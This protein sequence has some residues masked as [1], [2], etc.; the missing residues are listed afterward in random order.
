MNFTRGCPYKSVFCPNHQGQLYRAGPVDEL[1]RFTS[2]AVADDLDLPEEAEL[3][4]AR[5]LQDHL[6]VKSAPQLRVALHLLTLVGCDSAELSDLLAALGNPVVATDRRAMSAWQIKEA[7]LMAKQALLTSGRL[8]R[9]PP[10]ILITSEDNTLVNKGVIR[11]YLGKRT[12]SGLDEY[13][14]FDP[15]QNTVWD[16]TDAYGNAD[17][18]YI[19]DLVRRNPFA[20]ALGVDG[21]SNPVIRQNSKPRYTIGNA[22]AVNR[23]LA[24]HGVVVTNNYILLTPETDLLEAVEA[25]ALFVLLPLPWRDYGHSV[26]LRVIKEEGT[27]AH[28]EGLIFAPDDAGWD[29]PLRF[30]EVADLLDRWSLTSRVASDELRPLLLKILAEDAA[31]A[32]LLP[33]VVERWQRNYDSDEELRA[34]SGLI[35]AA[36][37]PEVPLIETLQAVSRETWACRCSDDEEPVSEATQR[38]SQ[39]T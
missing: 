26:N 7:W 32:P 12:E 29:E 9:K 14:I 6:G 17:E 31:A 11:E 24:R 23:A 30:G 2:L 1:W 28:D 39:P 27:L 22:L 5:R 21:S 34:I 15:G 3:A 8:R 19:S 18:D 16:L 37:R 38:T 10:F 4:T 33:L 13:V 25:F 36:A 35:A 20:V